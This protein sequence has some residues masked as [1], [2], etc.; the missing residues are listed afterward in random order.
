MY[1]KALEGF[2]FS[3]GTYIPKNTFVTVASTSTQLDAANYPN[4]LSFDPFRHVAGDNPTGRRR[5]L[6]LPGPDFLEFGSGRHVC[7]GRFFAADELKLLLAHVVVSYDIKLG[8]ET[9]GQRPPNTWFAQAC[10][11]NLRGEVMLRKRV[12]GGD[13]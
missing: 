13:V 5:D 7:P 11:P 1:R 3:D 2:T 4:P 6:V 12:P 8:E 10:M 9:G